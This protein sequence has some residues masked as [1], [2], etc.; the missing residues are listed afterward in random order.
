[1]LRKLR[2]QYPMRDVPGHEPRGYEPT[3]QTMLWVDPVFKGLT[4]VETALS[5]GVILIGRGQSSC[6]R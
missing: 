2:I 6:P 5:G 4:A 1:M 3:N